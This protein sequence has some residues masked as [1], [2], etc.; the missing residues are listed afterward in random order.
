VTRAVLEP[1]APAAATRRPW[2]RAAAMAWTFESAWRVEM[3]Q[4]AFREVFSFSPLSGDFQDRTKNE[5]AHA[6][7]RMVGGGCQELAFR[8]RVWER[9]TRRT[10]NMKVNRTDM[11]HPRRMVKSGGRE[12]Q[13]IS[14]ARRA[15]VGSKPRFYTRA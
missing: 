8:T 10:P 7:P 3:N 1:A 13:P 6:C 14:A 9:D 11:R 2:A 12:S 15:R 5:G 4:S